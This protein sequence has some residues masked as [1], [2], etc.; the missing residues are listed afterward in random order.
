MRYKIIAHIYYG[1]SAVP[2]IWVVSLTLAHIIIYI[3]HTNKISFSSFSISFKHDP[4]EF[5]YT[6]KSRIQF[7]ELCHQINRESDI[8]K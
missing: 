7:R 1:A 4:N 6:V 3:Y 8:W 5:Y 2:Q